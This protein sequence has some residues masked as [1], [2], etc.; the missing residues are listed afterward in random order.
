M[1]FDPR[2]P[3]PVK[4]VRF[5]APTDAPGLSVAS[6]CTASDQRNRSRHSI[7]YLPQIRHFELTYHPPDGEAQVAYIHESRVM[8]WIAADSFQPAPA[9]R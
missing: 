4:L 5:I 2:E 6:S 3:I 7:T 8:S 1:K 9:K